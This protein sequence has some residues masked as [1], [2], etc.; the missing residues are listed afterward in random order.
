M[1]RLVIEG[2][3]G[4]GKTRMAER[5]RD[6]HG[7]TLRHT[8]NQRFTDA[9]PHDFTV[10][11]TEAELAIAIKAEGGR[12]LRRLPGMIVASPPPKPTKREPEMCALQSGSVAMGDLVRKLY[13]SELGRVVRVDGDRVWVEWGVG[14]VVV[15]VATKA[16]D[17]PSLPVVTPKVAP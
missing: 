7:M 15:P 3:M 2:Q 1:T 16:C 10:L 12:I 11:E 4:S 8:E 17:E 9:N 13:S 6:E 14:T 5:L